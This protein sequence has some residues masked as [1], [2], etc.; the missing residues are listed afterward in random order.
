MLIGVLW[1]DVPA[2]QT[3]RETESRQVQLYTDYYHSVTPATAFISTIGIWCRREKDI[4]LRT[5]GLTI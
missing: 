4:N 2:N 1:L 3:Q 5:A